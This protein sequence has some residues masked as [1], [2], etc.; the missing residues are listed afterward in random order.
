MAEPK[1]IVVLAGDG[2]GPEVTDVAARVLREAAAR[3]G[4]PIE[5]Q[6]ALLGGAALTATGVPLPEETLSAIDGAAAILAGAV[7]G[8]DW[9]D[10]PAALNPGL[11]GMLRLRKDFD[12]YA[13]LRP[14][15]S[16]PGSARPIDVLL[17]REAVGGAYF[18]QPRG[19]EPGRDGRRAFDT[20]AYTEHEVRRV[21][22]IAARIAESRRGTI[23][24]VDK[25]NV[26][27][28]SRLWREVAHE[29]L[30]GSGLQVS[31]LYVDNAAYQLAR[32]A[33]RFDVIVTENMFGDILSD[34]LA[35]IVGSLGAA[36]SASLGEGAFGLYEPVHGSAP[37]IAGTGTANP[38]AAILSAALLLRHSL[39]AEPAARTVEAASDR[40]LARGFGTPDME[41]AETVVST[42]ELGDLVVDALGDDDG[43]ARVPG[44]GQSPGL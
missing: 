2:I 9:D 33:S 43:Y 1:K 18:S 6:P 24:S 14:A 25:A 36:P 30:Q 19:R 16:L 22:R 20:I 21:I 23:A 39:G 17:V 38:L 27:E 26:L 4:I 12:L 42:A 37:D 28:S 44:S 11:G 29:E 7:G 40:V 5:L 3:H 31:H 32:D 34:Q 35:G 15:V 13:N 8:P 10:L 41:G